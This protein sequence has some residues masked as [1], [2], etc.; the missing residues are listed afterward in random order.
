MDIR[1][2]RILH[3][4]LEKM[5][6]HSPLREGLAGILESAARDLGY[7]RMSLAILKPVSKII[8]FS[9][10]YGPG[11][12]PK[13]SYVPGEGITGT[14]V[15]KKEPI[16]VPCMAEEESFLNLAFGRKP[17]E[18]QDLSF[19][20]VPVLRKDP[21]GIPE[22]LGVL[23]ADLP[24]LDE[25]TLNEHCLFLQVL[26]Q[27]IA[28]QTSFLQDEITRQRDNTFSPPPGEREKVQTDIIATSK[29]MQEV[30]GQ[31]GQAA[32]SEATVLIRGESGT[33]KELLAEAIHANSPRAKGPFIRLNCAALPADLLESELFGHEQGAFTGAVK[34]KKGR[35]E[36][37]HEGSLFLDEIAE[38]SAAAQAK[39]LRALQEGEVQRL[40]SEK[41]TQVDVR[42]VCATHQ[43]L[44]DLVSSGG[45]REDLY[46]RINVFPLFIP[47]LQERKEDILPVAEHFLQEFAEKYSKDI[48]RISTPAIDL[49]MQYHWPGNVRELKNC[50]ERAVLVCSEEVIRTYHL[51]P[52]LQTAESS[53]TDTQF[54]FKEAVARFEQELLVE[55]LKKNKGNMLQAARELRVTY[56]ILHYKVHKYRLDPDKY[57]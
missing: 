9:L 56:R 46:Y 33:G 50:V 13:H 25:N 12:P 24:R 43:P 40:G 20:C 51:P 44:E 5:D 10:Y 16:V 27:I 55:A 31:V 38:L 54:S 2:T 45:F 11:R 35:F 36:L 49:L 28:R 4:I 15:Q 32:P 26:A 29:A 23:S 21:E 30:L 34:A 17:E 7:K 8:E 1:F 3:Q 18:L 37:A 19:I 52:S 14:V 22:I 53:A 47:P 39:L 42:I 48:R 41:A 6:L 57:K